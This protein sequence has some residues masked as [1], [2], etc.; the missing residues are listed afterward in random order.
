[1]S[2]LLYTTL[3]TLDTSFA[4]PLFG[5]A[6]EIHHIK[7]LPI[8]VDICFSSRQAIFS[9]DHFSTPAGRQ[10][11]R[12]SFKPLN[13]LHRLRLVY[14]RHSLKVYAHNQ[15]GNVHGTHRSIW[16]GWFTGQSRVVNITQIVDLWYDYGTH[17]VV[18]NPLEGSGGRAV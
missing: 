6:K 2:W 13:S 7:S 14:C 10:T 4:R 1:M 8:I 3:H 16:G 18:S 11:L 5:V 12:L 17:F 9:D 15:P